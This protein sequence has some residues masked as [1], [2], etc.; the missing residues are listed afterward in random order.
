VR[1]YRQLT[2]GNP[3]FDVIGDIGMR[4]AKLGGIQGLLQL[5]IIFLMV[6]LRFGYGLAA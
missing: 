4:N 5:S 1:I 6:G 3:D 2:S